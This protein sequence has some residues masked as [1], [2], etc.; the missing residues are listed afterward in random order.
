VAIIRSQ[1]ISAIGDGLRG[2]DQEQAR[3]DDRLVRGAQVLFRAVHDGTHTLLDRV[4]LGIDSRDAGEALGALLFAVDHP[5][6]VLVAR[7]PEVWKLLP[8]RVA[9]LTRAPL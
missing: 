8:A 6:V 3:R 2:L 7:L 9:G 4:V 5:V 1:R